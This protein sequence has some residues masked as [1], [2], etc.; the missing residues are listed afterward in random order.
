[1]KPRLFVLFLCASMA[2]AVCAR[3]KTILP[4]ACGSDDVKFKVKAREGQP[5]PTAPEAGKAQVVFVEVMDKTG[6]FTG[7]AITR[8]G[9]D[10][11][12]VGAN[13]GDSYF[14]F[15]VTPGD[16]HLCADWQA[17]FGPTKEKVGLDF[18]KAEP[19]KIYY[20]QVKITV[21]SQAAQR[22]LVLTRLSEDEGKYR[23]K[24]SP[25]SIATPHP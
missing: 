10:G 1:M 7:D 6:L 19:G 23:I 2:L 3:A 9:V 16:H 17:D 11:A 15:T 13:K 20:Y 21:I 8:I 25:Y 18:F 4:D 12:W 24:A 5:V 14:T 22:S